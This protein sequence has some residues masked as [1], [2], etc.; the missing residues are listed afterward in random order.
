MKASRLLALLC[1]MLILVGA[2]TA[3]SWYAG[4][5]DQTRI[6]QFVEQINLGLAAQWPV[7]EPQALLR[8]ED[9]QR[10]WFSS[11]IHYQFVF[12]GEDGRPQHIA[13]QDALNHGPWPWAALREGDWHPAMAYSQ[14]A[15]SG[16]GLTA[17]WFDGVHGGGGTPL[18]ISTRIGFDGTAHSVWLVRPAQVRASG[19]QL[20][21]GAGRLTVDYDADTRASS[22]QGSLGELTLL[23][24]DTGERMHLQDLSLQS[25]NA[26]S[27]D[28]GMQAHYRAQ[29]GQTT[30]QQPDAP[31]VGLKT[32]VV[33]LDAAQTGALADAQLRY[34]VDQVQVG[35]TD[36]GAFDLG[37]RAQQV[38]VAA[39]QALAQAW[40]D[41]TGD[42]DAEGLT[43]A[44]QAV[45]TQHL[46][47]V[48]AAGPSFLLEPASRRN[49][50]GRSQASASVIFQA[51][52]P[53]AQADTD[54]GAVLED[55]LRQ[56]R[57][58]LEVSRPMVI[59]A[60]RRASPHD[61]DRAAAM[62]G[63]MYDHFIGQFSRAGLIEL[64]QDV[65]RLDLSYGAG[66]VVLNGRSMPV[67]DFYALIS[68]L[69]MSQ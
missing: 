51:P 44:E 43:P 11:D 21:I 60:V 29:V 12:Q 9:Y 3:A 39:F 2:Y 19:M 16:G 7:S 34:T 48:L 22:A 26:F 24:L 30:I 18:M 5:E 62:A 1:T 8:I 42:D 20:D 40:A 4:R 33:M 61:A 50:K 64:Q 58:T 32:L 35:A 49:D 37:M 47:P 23:A 59:E 52:S 6:E 53:Q 66:Q 15:L 67:A 17:P 14:L 57:L 25:N 31:V 56:A 55:A 13:F 45:L 46:L 38:N 68:P 54:P 10:G 63:M 65:A 27:G 69:L 36:L 41:I 28:S